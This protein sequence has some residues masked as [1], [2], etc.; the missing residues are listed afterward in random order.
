MYDFIG[1]YRYYKKM[2]PR[3]VA[4]DVVIAVLTPLLP[5]KK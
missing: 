5:K 2:L 4:I 3:S 1:Q